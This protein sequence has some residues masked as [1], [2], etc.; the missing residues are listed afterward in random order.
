MS[1]HILSYP[2]CGYRPLIL[3]NSRSH[4]LAIMNF[5]LSAIAI[6]ITSLGERRLTVSQTILGAID[7]LV[8]DR[9]TIYNGTQ[10]AAGFTI[11]SVALYFGH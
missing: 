8:D 1:L 7:A 10:C 9:L 2:F 5:W 3:A 4:G 6:Y 11:K